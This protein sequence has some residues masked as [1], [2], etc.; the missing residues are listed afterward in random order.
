MFLTP[1]VTATL[2]VLLKPTVPRTKL[3]VAIT[4]IVTAAFQEDNSNT[5]H[6]AFPSR[7]RGSNSSSHTSSPPRDRGTDTTRRNA[8][9]YTYTAPL[10]QK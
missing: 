10:L 4:S 9:T 1:N 6:H 5:R 8:H 7:L 3:E 2:W